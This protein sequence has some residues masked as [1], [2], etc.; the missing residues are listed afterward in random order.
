[1]NNIEDVVLFQIDKT[2]KMSKIYSQ[3]ELDRLDFGLTVDQWILMKIIH[4]NPQISQKELAD[5]SLRDPASIT[6]TLDLLAKK[7]FT[8]RHAIPN[9]RRKYSIALTKSGNDF[10]SKHMDTIISHRKNS[11]NGLTKSEV[12]E[13]TTL[14]KKI[15][16]NFE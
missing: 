12:K 6:R 13:L 5:K 3:K 15:Q 16:A 11:I 7:G 8:E 4:E 14:L 2:S 9:D 1:M 10:I